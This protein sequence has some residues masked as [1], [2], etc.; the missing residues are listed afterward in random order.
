MGRLVSLRPAE[1]LCDVA[2][3]AD[4]RKAIALCIKAAQK[5]DRALKSPA[6]ICIL[7][8]FGDNAA[9]LE[10]RFWIYDPMNGV[11]AVLTCLPAFPNSLPLFPVF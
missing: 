4:V 11:S 2:Y 9:E 5:V 8:G 10:L 1:S 7:K 6:P 3:D